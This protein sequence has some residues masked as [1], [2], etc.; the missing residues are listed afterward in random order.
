MKHVIDADALMTFL[1]RGKGFEK[2]K[3]LF[4]E[5]VSKGQEIYMSSVDAGEVY[6]S[7]LEEYG[8]MK[9]NEVLS[10]IEALPIKVTDVDF[11]VTKKAAQLKSKGSPQRMVFALALSQVKKATLFD[12][13]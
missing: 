6:A 12:I 7:A 3:K 9:A 1:Q 13:H 4:M 2:I 11:K 8:P 10:A 5:S